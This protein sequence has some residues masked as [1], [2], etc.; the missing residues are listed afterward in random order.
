MIVSEW[1]TFVCYSGLFKAITIFANVHS[2]PELIKYMS[3]QVV[4]ARFELTTSYY[5]IRGAS[6]NHFSTT[7][8]EWTLNVNLYVNV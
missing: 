1:C 3:S 6:S 7:T 4:V 2:R 5:R 8:N